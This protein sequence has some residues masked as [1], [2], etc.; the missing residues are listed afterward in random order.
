MAI[1]M[2]K[3]I[4]IVQYHHSVKRHQSNIKLPVNRELRTK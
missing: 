1:A 4:N 3:H 2:A